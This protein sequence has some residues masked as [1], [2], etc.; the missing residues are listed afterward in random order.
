VG[1]SGC[2]EISEVYN[3]ILGRAQL[4]ERQIKDPKT[5]LVHNQGGHPGRFM[6]GV[7]ILGLP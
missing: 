6:A 7:V 4:P 2:R 1:A 5:G 3:Q